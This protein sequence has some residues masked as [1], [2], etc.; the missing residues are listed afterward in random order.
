[1]KNQK[2]I[3]DTHVGRL[4]L[5]LSR[6]F[7]DEANERI[8]KRGFPF[9][10]AAHIAVLAQVDENGTELATVINRLG[11]SKQ[12]VNKIIRRLEGHGIL[13]LRIN[14]RDSRARIVTFTAKGRRFLT[15]ALDAVQQVEQSYSDLLGAAEFETIKKR[16][17]LLCSK[18]ELL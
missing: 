8:R 14:E 5:A 1:M 2:N 6:D 17:A 12:A 11:E 9:V 10:R 15:V 7:I 3:R 13:E 4:L 18:R 16:L